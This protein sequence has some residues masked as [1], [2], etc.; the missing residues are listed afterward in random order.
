MDADH[1][2]RVFPR[3]PDKLP[4]HASQFKDVVDLLTDN[5]TARHIGICG[6]CPQ[7][8]QVFRQII[9]RRFF[10]AHDRQRDP[11]DSGEEAQQHARLPRDIRHDFMDL[12]QPGGKLGAV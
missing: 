8:A 12:P 6:N 3:D 1:E 7:T 4:D 9:V 5:I 2:S 10:I 11:A